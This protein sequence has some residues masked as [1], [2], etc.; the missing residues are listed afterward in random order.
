MKLPSVAGALAC[1]QFAF[2]CNGTIDS[3]YTHGGDSAGGRPGGG[4][5]SGAGGASVVGGQGGGLLADAGELDGTSM[6]AALDA[7]LDG[8]SPGDA[9][10]PIPDATSIA[11]DGSF[12]VPPPI[13]IGCDAM[14]AQT[15]ADR[16]IAQLMFG[17]WNGGTN[18][19]DAAE[20]TN[21]SRTGYW[22]F[23]QAFDSV[24]D[25]VERT[26]GRRYL[27]LIQTLYAAQNGSTWRS[28][29]YDDESWMA[30]ALIHAYDLTGDRAY[31]DRAVA[32][33]ADITAAWDATSAHPGGIWWNRP[34]TQKATASNGG[35]VIIGARLTARTGDPA[36]LA[37][38]RQV[39]AFWRANMTNATT[40]ETYDHMSP[41]GTI[42]KGRLTYNEGIMSGAA[43]ALHAATGEA[44]FR[45]DAHGFATRLAKFITKAT[46]AGPVLADGTNTSCTRDC[47]QWKGIGYRYL[48]AAFRDDPTRPDYLP[49]L[50]GSVAAAWT[51][52]RSVTTGYFANDWA[53]PPMSTAAIEAQSST[54]TALNLYAMLCGSYLAP[55]DAGYEA[56][57]AVL[58]PVGVEETNAGFSGWGYVSSWTANNQFVEFSIRV[59]AAGSYRLDFDYAAAAQAVRTLLVGGVMTQPRLLFPATGGVATWGR[60][61]TTVT[62]AAG[63]NAIRLVYQTANASTAALN[64]DRLLVTH[65]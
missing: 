32:L 20:P 42:G 7:S 53:G 15:R 41:D 8:R 48:A 58:D 57:D 23:A 24:I 39:Y 44:Q 62:L 56:E 19:L 13:L 61:S 21:N 33:Y 34:H 6:D 59:D 47:P 50:Q 37:F 49:V 2:G 60:A 14:T 28:D 35:P 30:L 27:G 5:G 9:L 54:A 4:S 25:G 22:T 51:L 63:S 36:H 43:L 52:A 40:Y 3:G 38:A 26:G 12:G 16:S 45:A 55:A 1:L 29:Y 18:Y 11:P 65:L 17:L 64:L 46:S 31:L 10:A